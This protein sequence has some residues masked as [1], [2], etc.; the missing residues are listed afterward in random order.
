MKV[1]IAAP[2]FNEIEIERNRALRDFL[3]TLN[4]ETYLPQEDGGI[5]YDLIKEGADTSET[6]R[7]IFENDVQ[8]VKECDILLCVLDGRVPDEGMCIELG[9][10]YALGKTCI[11]YLTDKRSLDVYGLSLM[12]DGCLTATVCSRDEL[13]NILSQ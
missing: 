9:I 3:H 4:Y 8:E 1:Y 13:R 11:G 2:L 5:S 12:I 10:G 7:K 6:R